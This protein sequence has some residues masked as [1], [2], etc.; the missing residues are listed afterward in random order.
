MTTPARTIFGFYDVDSRD[1]PSAPGPEYSF[2]PRVRAA[3]EN[4]T[5]L[6]RAAEQVGILA[7][8]RCLTIC[9]GRTYRL[10][11]EAGTLTIP[12]DA[13]LDAVRDMIRARR[14][15]FERVEFERRSCGKREDNVRA[16]SH[17]VFHANPAAAVAIEE[18][19]VDRWFVFGT[20]LPGCL[21]SVVEGLLRSGQAVTVAG[22]AVWDVPRAMVAFA[23]PD[24]IAAITNGDEPAEHHM[25]RFVQAYLERYRRLGATVQTTREI[26]DEAATALE[27]DM[28]GGRR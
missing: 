15:D 23:P 20:S 18:L 24:L 13:D 6:I 3:G 11:V 26:L 2:R 25:P 22:D 21:A 16:R 5:R 27:A 1:D 7:A 4:L 17:D 19:G 12:V 8:T 28:A 9:L 10:A 14:G